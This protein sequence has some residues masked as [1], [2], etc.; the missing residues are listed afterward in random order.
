MDSSNGFWS[1]SNL[2]KDIKY[3]YNLSNLVGHF[4][5]WDG[6]IQLFENPESLFSSKII[7][8]F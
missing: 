8:V 3:Y 6:S 4:S 5:I 2:G 7:L 1:G